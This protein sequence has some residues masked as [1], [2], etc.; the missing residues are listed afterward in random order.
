M[1]GQCP[2][3]TDLTRSCGRQLA[4]MFDDVTEG[5]WRQAVC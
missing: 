3:Y 2:D 5:L 4:D 1:D